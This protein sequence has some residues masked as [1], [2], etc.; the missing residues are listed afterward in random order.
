[1]GKFDEVLAVIRDGQK[2]IIGPRLEKSMEVRERQCGFT[3]G[4]PTRSNEKV[5]II[6]KPRRYWSTHP[7]GWD[8]W[9]VLERSRHIFCPREIEVLAMTGTPCR[10]TRKGYSEQKWGLKQGD[11]S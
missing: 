3:T 11:W 8:S 2:L 6:Y 10:G 7:G 4:W 9:A 1:M 5:I